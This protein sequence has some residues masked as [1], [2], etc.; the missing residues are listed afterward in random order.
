MAE[1]GC[2]GIGQPAGARQRGSHT[3]AK[4]VGVE[5]HRRGGGDAGL[6]VRIEG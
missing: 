4:H 1:L 2:R 6:T 3:G 5:P